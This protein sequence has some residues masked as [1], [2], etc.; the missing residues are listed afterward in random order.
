MSVPDRLFYYYESTRP[1][2]LSISELNRSDFSHLMEEF[3]KNDTVESRFDE[4]WKRDFY[5]DFRPYTESVI[6]ERFIQK[7]GRPKLTKPRYLALGR[8]DWFLDWYKNPAFLDIPL[9]D[10]PEDQVSFTYPDSMMSLLIAEDRFEPFRKFKQ[11]YHGQVYRL[12]ELP[13]LID[14][15]GLPDPE[16]PINQEYG[17]R[18]IEA[19]V[20]DL[21]LLQP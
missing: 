6:R 13:A 12:D 18:L 15:F 4:A 19:Q 10:I 17:N 9:S 1:P 14:E 21:E 11:P 20:W 3:S 16:D 7:G 8:C 5:L 2:F